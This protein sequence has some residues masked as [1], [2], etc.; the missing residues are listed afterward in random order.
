MADRDVVLADQD[1][2]DDK[3]DDVLALLDG[4]A[5]GVRG[6]PGPEPVECLGEL[7]VGLGVV[8]LGVERVRLGLHRR[9]TLAQLGRAGAQLL[10]RDQLLLVAVQQPPQRGLRAGEVALERVPTPG[11]RVRRAHRLEPAVDLG[12]DQRGVL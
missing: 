11:G 6:E 12:L 7:E 10:K 2:A 1:L 4:Q 5:L 8:Q 3:P 9:L